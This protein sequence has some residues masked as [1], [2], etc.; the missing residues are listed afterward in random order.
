MKRLDPFSTT[1]ELQ[2]AYAA[3]SAGEVIK[4]E[5]HSHATQLL[6]IEQGS[7]TIVT[8]GHN[9][10]ND[11]TRHNVTEGDFFVLPGGVYHEIRAS[12]DTDLKLT[13]IYAPVIQH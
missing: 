12:P 13:T 10:N 8:W 4:K 1:L 2:C 6:R 7:G 3:V 5:H 9:P 11:E